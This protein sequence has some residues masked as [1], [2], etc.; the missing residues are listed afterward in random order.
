L[1]QHSQKRRR[2]VWDIYEQ[3]KKTWHNDKNLLLLR[4]DLLDIESAKVA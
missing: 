2:E 1:L 3:A 4:K